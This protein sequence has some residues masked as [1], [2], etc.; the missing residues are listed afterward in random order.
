MEAYLVSIVYSVLKSSGNE[1]FILILLLTRELDFARPQIKLVSPSRA[2]F[3]SPSLYN[4]L[5]LYRK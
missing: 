1:F 3:D 5:G 4:E 2:L